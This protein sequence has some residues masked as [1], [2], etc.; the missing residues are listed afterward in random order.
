MPVFDR[1]PFVRASVE[2]VLATGY[3]ELEVVV[4]DDGSTDDTSAILEDL[5]SRNEAVVRILH[6]PGGRNLGPWASRNLALAAATGAYICF[7]DS[8]DIMLPYRFERAVWLLD[9]NPGLDGIVEV[10]ELVFDAEQDRARW[11]KRALR[12]G[13][14]VGSI[15]AGGF[16]TACLLDRICSMHT[17]NILVRARLFE[18]TGVFR[19]T[20]E[21]S[22]DFH[23]WLRMAAC[24]RFAVGEMERPVT[25]YRRHAGNI[26]S[27]DPLD[28]LRDAAVLRDALAWAQRSR[29][30]TPSNVTVL[31]QAYRRKL[32]WCV[33]ILRSMADRENALRFVGG[34]FVSGHGRALDL[35][36]VADLARLALRR[37]PRCDVV[38]RTP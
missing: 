36:L 16:L 9:E 3:P 11:G 37:P 6:H 38:G 4:V 12:Y 21:R 1:A 18:R 15:P 8:D 31:R 5:R 17:S 13:P 30:V 10:A 28:S 26:W 25:L 20:S 35:R 14:Q 34:V 24:G 2:S 22:E 7:L 27:P 19:A 23:L 29:H 33:R 32:R